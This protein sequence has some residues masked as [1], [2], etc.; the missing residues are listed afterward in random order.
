MENQ[1][2]PVCQDELVLEENKVLQVL[3]V[4]LVTQ[5]SEELV[6]DEVTMVLEV[7]KVPRVTPVPMVF[8]DEPVKM[9]LQD[10]TVLT[11]AISLFDT[12]KN[13]L[14]QLVQTILTNCGMVT[15]CSILKVMNWS[16]LK[17]SAELVL[18]YDNLAP[19]H[20]CSAV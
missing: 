12:V 8:Q 3:M 2:L 15:H 9:E 11:K 1:V 4:P 17:I 19:C 18:V 5:V 16:I 6:D 13:E 20:S 14:F 7:Q 10:P